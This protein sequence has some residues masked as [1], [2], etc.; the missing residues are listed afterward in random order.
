MPDLGEIVVPG[1]RVDARE[2]KEPLPGPEVWVLIPVH[3]SLGFASIWLESREQLPKQQ[4]SQSV[5]F[6]IPWFS[7][8]DG[9]KGGYHP[10][11][12]PPP[13]ISL[14]NENS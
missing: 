12:F 8:V 14:N 3:S 4:P 2:E 9:G 5:R 13:G 11:T 6:N 7:V 10:N 1:N